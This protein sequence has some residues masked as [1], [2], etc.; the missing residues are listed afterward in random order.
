MLR[1]TNKKTKMQYILMKN[2][3]GVSLMLSYV[4]LIAIVIGLSI[5]VYV[6]LKSFI[7]TEK[8]DCDEGTSVILT[9]YEINPGSIKLNIKNNGRFNVDGIIFT[10][11]N[12]SNKNP[13]TYLIPYGITSTDPERFAGV[14]Y[15]LTQLKPGD[16][17]TVEFTDKNK[18]SETY[19]LNLIKILQIQP[20]IM[21][22]KGRIIC[23]N[24]IFKENI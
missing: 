9:N 4:I 16:E 13:N 7:I 22:K 24:A 6:W 8:V 5:G 23:S 20:F 10:V 19:Y 11:S 17:K 14:E 15:F 1:E 21:G 12:D 3:I 2:K 18:N